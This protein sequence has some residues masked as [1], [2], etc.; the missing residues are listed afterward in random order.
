[1][2][3]IVNFPFA[4]LTRAVL[5]ASW[6]PLS[7]TAFHR[8]PTFPPYLTTTPYHGSDAETS[9]ARLRIDF[10]LQMNSNS[11]DD[12]GDNQE[13]MQR[14]DDNIGFFDPLLSPHSYPDGTDNSPVENP[15]DGYGGYVDDN[16]ASSS[17]SVRN[18]SSSSGSGNNSPYASI[19]SVIGTGP[20]DF[21]FDPLLSPHSYPD[22]TDAGPVP[23]M[24]EAVALYSNS[25]AALSNV[26][27]IMDGENT[28]ENEEELEDKESLCDPLEVFDP[29]LSPHDYPDGIPSLPEECTDSDA[30]ASTN[31]LSTIPSETNNSGSNNFRT[32]TQKLGILLIDHGSKRQ[33]S[34]DNLHFIA[35]VYES[36]LLSKSTPASKKQVAVRGAHMEIATPSI[37]TSLRTLLVEDQ[38]ESIVCVPYFLSPGRHA[39]EDVPN[40]IEEAK[41][42]LEKEGL[43]GER[44]GNDEGRVQVRVSNALGSHLESMM[45]AVDD[46]VEW[47]LNGE[48]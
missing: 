25:V 37:L 31:T 41:S 5:S 29:L 24:H 27:A 26:D 3:P 28:D 10:P 35:K 38:V 12:D 32:K 43:L 46:L 45:G 19:T 15:T 16:D 42:V 13:G 47:T 14:S 21:E 9:P 34:N 39:T 23:A 17:S 8:H 11:N 48:G 36:K 30:T 22:G 6:L 20:G 1:M 40:L 7:A 18:R 33:A 44:N 2:M 4:S